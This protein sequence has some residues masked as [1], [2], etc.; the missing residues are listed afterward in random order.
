MN[1]D[2][3]RWLLDVEAI[4]KGSENLRL[5]WEHPWPS[6]VWAIL[7][8][9]AGML[10]VWSY[11]R[12]V[13]RRI[14]RG[15]L[16]AARFAIIFLALA[17][18]SG[19]MLELPRETVEQDWVLMLADRSASMTIKDAAADSASGRLSRDEQLRSALESQSNVLDSM[20][21]QRHVMWIGFHLGAFNLQS[22]Q[23]TVPGWANSSASP[24]QAAGAGLPDLT[25]A[26][27]RR[28][29]IDGALEQAIQRAAARPVSGIV[30]F[31]DGRTDNPPSR[32]L[33]RRLQADAIP[34]FVVPLGSDEPLGDLALGRV[35][36]PRRA[37]VRDK[38]PVVVELDKF[39]SALRDQGGSVKLIDTATGEELDRLALEPRSADGSPGDEGASDLTTL[40]LTAEPALAGE[41]TWQVV[42]DTPQV[43][44]IPENNVKS[45]QI[46]L[47]DRPL[48][49]LFVEGYPRWEYRYVKNLLVRE[50]Y[51]ESSVMLISADRD[52]AQEGNQ[53]ITRLP[54]SPEEFAAFDV[55]IMGDVPATFF[56]PEQ[57]DMIRDHVANRGAGLLWIAGEHSTPSS[58]LGTALADLLPMRGSLNLPPIGEP[59]T[60]TPTPLAQRLGVLQL[61]TA[62]DS[63]STQHSALSTSV[64]GG[65]PAELSDPATGW[66]LLYYAQRIEPGQLKPAAE[67]LAQ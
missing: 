20:A 33:I 50:K 62:A 41:A 2:L 17:L 42:I 47:V 63:L 58:F 43:D 21:R 32:A 4:P 7:F 53:P 40:T 25:E 46:E 52:F 49:V 13:G 44:L 14:G 9:G 5:V 22:R 67:V 24:P 38:V 45:F 8:V 30:L 29:N 61:E 54:R 19:P 26:T 66:S 48:R 31:S 34:V 39:G 15:I 57:L 3:M 23:S 35:E 27:G 55:I 60:M 16:A 18:I 56:A 65:W 1:S 36:A 28:T 10:A 64:P 12:L 51:V 6:W 37:F 11:H 59:V